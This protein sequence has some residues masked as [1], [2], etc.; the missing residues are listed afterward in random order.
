MSEGWHMAI[1]YIIDMDCEVKRQLTRD[2]LVSMI[3]QRDRAK[4]I[5]DLLEK[6]GRSK[7]EV[8]SHKFK[9]QFLTPHGVEEKEQ[10]VS[11]LLESTRHLDTL[12]SQC[13]ACALRLNKVGD[14]LSG[15]GP[16]IG[17]FGCY[18]SINYPI[19]RRAEEWLAERAREALARGGANAMTLNYILDNRVTGREMNALRRG[20]HRR[21]LELERPLD[22]VVGKGLL[23]KKTVNTGQ[24]LFMLFGSPEVQRAQMVMLLYFADALKIGDEKPDGGSCQVAVSMKAGNGTTNYW[25]LNLKD[26]DGDDHSVLQLKDFFRSMFLACVL[27]QSIIIDR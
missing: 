25:S 17:A 2:G 14:A 5:M 12:Q 20:P 23:G 27:G 4:A 7:E 21:Y 8:L 13:N 11:D 26:R 19:S 9:V 24:L 10:T 1:D 22:V 18:G 16:A 15:P 3:K 6:E